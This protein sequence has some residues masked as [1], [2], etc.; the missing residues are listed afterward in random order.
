MI[1]SKED[2]RQ[3]MN[4]SIKELVELS[5]RYGSFSE[6]VLAGGGNT[7]CKTE[8]TLYVKGSGTQ[9]ATITAE[10]FVKMDRK[11][12]AAM[13]AKAY[14]ETVAE[15]EKQVL[16]DLTAARRVGEENKRPSVETSLHDLI[17]YTF[18]LH[19]HPALINGL[20]CGKNGKKAA[21]EIFK[22]KAAWIDATKPGWVLAVETK[23][24]IDAFSKKNKSAPQ[25]ILIQNH[26]VF[27]AADTV[28]ELDKIVK[29]CMGA[30]SAKAKLDADEFLA[31]TGLDRRGIVEATAV[32][33][34][35]YRRDNG[36]A[37]AQ[38]FGKNAAVEK[39]CE[40]Q[41]S[42]NES[43]RKPFTPDQIVY[44]KAEP[45]Y[46]EDVS[47]DGVIKAYEAYFAKHKYSPKIVFAKG[48]GMI[49]AGKTK[50]E[51]SIAWQV[52]WDAVLV[53]LYSQSFGGPLF[54]ADEDVD[55]I[56][57]W[58][59]ESYRQK[60]SLAGG[61]GKRLEG[62]IAFITGAAQGFGKGIAELMAK[63]GSCVVIADLNYDGAKATADAINAECG[64]DTATAV[65]VDV[66]DEESVEKA[67]YN[68]V[69]FYGGL[70]VLVN[71]AG[72]LKA[73]GL[74]ETDLKTIEFITK[75]NYTGY[76]LCAKYAS[77]IM[78]LQH[79]A[80][81]TRF[82]D[83]IQINSKSGLLGSKNNFTY[84]G[85]K[86][87]GI[88]LTQSFALELIPYNIKVNAV[89]PG[90][91]FDGPLW[92]DPEK[93]LFVQYLKS[94]KVPGAKTIADVKAFYEAKV[95]MNRGCFEIDVA[96]AIYY[97]IEQEYE[98]GQAVP[99]TGGQNMLK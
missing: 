74:E 11:K 99:V 87:G 66:G 29:D 97:I 27:F 21:A 69:L 9:L 46:I 71:N 63:E 65:K 42:F 82:A 64:K 85:S 91:F 15:R 16:A 23:K 50:N 13:W 79:K 33:R 48:L 94:N 54:M 35:L 39:I 1:E 31:P 88:G 22:G 10:G 34:A 55:F 93:G 75:I 96:R 5:N 25:I 2:E 12:L 20:T 98:T 32:F 73:G 52:F 19:V 41:K 92:A 70:D 28:A 81:G 37:F 18:V 45:L 56:V 26:G 59:V 80:D 62:K 49:S 76:F 51:A 83:I 3:T 90:N 6:F 84:A 95:P 47:A 86:F 89:C 4:I 8:D 68:T 43:I 17:S 7:S 78:K 24:A 61:S 38:C 53:Y 77:R 72:V 30:V 14:S 40:S 57:N 44:C 36:T 67:I 60:V 58:E